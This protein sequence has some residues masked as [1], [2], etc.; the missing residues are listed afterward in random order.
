MISFNRVCSRVL[1]Y[2]GVFLCL[3]SASVY[4]THA[5]APIVIEEHSKVVTADATTND[6]GQVE[7]WGSYVVQGGKFGWRSNGERQK[8]GTY[9]AQSWET[10]TTVGL[11][12]D[13]DIGIIQWFQHTL[14]KE[15]NYD[16]FRDMLD[17][18]TGGAAED[19]TEGPS[20]GFGWS[21]LGI[22]GRW[23]FYDSAE[24]KLEIAYIPTIYVPTGR[25]SNLEHIGASQGY[26]SL[27]NAFAFTKDIGRWNGT[28]NLGYNTPLAHWQRTHY[29]YG[30]AHF[31]FA[32][33]YQVLPWFQ[34]EAELIYLHDFGGHGQTGNLFSV[35]AGA[36][37]PFGDHLR[38]E[39]GVQ[40]DVFGSNK[41]QTT[42]GIFSVAI[43]T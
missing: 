42:S 5:D 30:T 41:T 8:R 24:K 38:F 19:T 11:C 6:P 16:E 2:C 34:P 12:R 13:L 39:I 35:V 27:D 10:Q 23:R 29:Y 22:S 26:T 21:D 32:A 40:Q 25:R 37:M 3:G 28:V 15:N 36:V 43:L 14:D 20:H 9:L 7:F 31:N 4:A 33:G 17:P 1:V 18:D